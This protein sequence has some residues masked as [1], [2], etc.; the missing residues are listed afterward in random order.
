MLVLERRYPPIG[1]RIRRLAEETIVP[2]RSSKGKDRP[3]RR[4][5]QRRQH[6]RDRRAQGP[7]RRNPGLH[8]LR[9]QLQSAAADLSVDVRTDRVDRLPEAAP[10]VF[11]FFFKKKKKKKKKKRVYWSGTV[12]VDLPVCR[13]KRPKAARSGM[14]REFSHFQT[15]R[16]S[17][18][19]IGMRTILPFAAKVPTAFICT[20][21]L[22]RTAAGADCGLSLQPQLLSNQT[23]GRLLPSPSLDGLQ[24]RMRR[25]NLGVPDA[26]DCAVAQSCK[27]VV[28]CTGI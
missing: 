5:A 23:T 4:I 3:P 19:M 24:K 12:E 27:T 25:I 17:R 13:S 26:Q 22:W 11:F 28:G 16:T 1:V 7:R 20:L 15:S 10:G 8:R 21:H 2:A 14:G 6:G 18:C 9:R